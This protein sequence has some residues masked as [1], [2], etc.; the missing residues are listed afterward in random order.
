MRK[1]KGRSEKAETQ[2]AAGSAEIGEGGGGGGGGKGDGDGKFF[3]C[4]LLASL[5]PR[6]K[7]HT[8][9]GFTVNPRRRIRQHNG[10][11]MCG[12]WRTKGKRPWEMVFCIYG[13]PSHVSALQFEWA[14]QHPRESL[15]VRTAASEFKSLSGI[16]NK[17]KLAYTMLNLPSWQSFNIRVN[18]FS[19]KYTKHSAG[20]PSLP[21]HMKVQICPMD[22]LPCYS[23]G[24]AV[25]MP[26]DEW[27]GEAEVVD[28]DCNAHRLDEQLVRDET[29]YN[30]RDDEPWV[31]RPIYGEDNGAGFLPVGVQSSVN[32]SS[33]SS[34]EGRSAKLNNQ[35]EEKL[36]ETASTANNSRE[37]SGCIASEEIE[38]IELFT[39]S[40]NCT[41]SSGKRRRVSTI[42]SEI[43][44]LTQSPIFV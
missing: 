11:L 14:W 16:G 20:C 25:S 27:E 43:I 23:D 19:T 6:H 37:N 1:R 36:P 26:D 34:D 22:E 38:I 40:P 17:I 41:S 15:A 32:P 18:Y 21:E 7:G 12:A 9:I 28:E 13:F 42:C 33:F 39:P 2:A 44:D 30:L 31:H 8:Y 3:A 5:S 4:Y 29:I 24:I 10:E 35:L